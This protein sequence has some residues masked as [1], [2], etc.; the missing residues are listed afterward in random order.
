MFKSKGGAC[1]L[2][3]KTIR[4]K[5]A[6]VERLQSSV[7]NRNIANKILASRP[8]RPKLD[9][10]MGTFIGASLTL[11]KNTSQTFFK[12]VDKFLPYFTDNEFDKVD[13]ILVAIEKEQTQKTRTQ[14]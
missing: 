9:S 5:S 10:N 2:S 4:N 12:K 13:K 6:V 1:S 3:N 7:N 11:N 8:V 14:Y